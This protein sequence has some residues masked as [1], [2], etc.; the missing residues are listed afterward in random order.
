MGAIDDL[1]ALAALDSDEDLWLDVD[2]CIGALIAIAPRNA[3]RVAGTESRIRSLSIT[4]VAACAV[5]MRFRPGRDGSLI[6]A[7][8]AVRPNIFTRRRAASRPEDGSHQWGLQTS[9]DPGTQ[10]LDRLR[11]TASKSSDV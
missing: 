11:S 7:T 8:V 3:Y 9:R 10:D 6:E 5:Q 4:T 2:G 1:L